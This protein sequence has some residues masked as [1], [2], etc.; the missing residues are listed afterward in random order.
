VA[1]AIEGNQVK[2]QCVFVRCGR[3]Y[4]ALLSSDGALQQIHRD[5]VETLAAKAKLGPADWTSRVE[6]LFNST[7]G[8]HWMCTH[9]KNE[10]Q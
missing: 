7:D 5:P 4:I 1:D 2:I 9:L 3:I 8:A 10:N 6:G